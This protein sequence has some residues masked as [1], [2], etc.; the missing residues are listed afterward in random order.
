MKGQCVKDSKG[1]RKMRMKGSRMKEYAGL[2]RKVRSMEEEGVKEL[3][4]DE[5][6]EYG[7][8]AEG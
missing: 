8:R 3:K 2:W 7:R 6:G 5:R 1:V 4:E